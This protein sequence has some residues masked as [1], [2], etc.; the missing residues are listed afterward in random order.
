MTFNSWDDLLDFLE[1]L[2]KGIAANFDEQTYNVFVFGSSIREDYNPM[3][4]DLDLAVYACTTE[5]TEGIADFIRDYLERREVPY[6]LIEI[7]TEQYDAYVCVE[8]LGLNVTFTSY[9]PRELKE[10]FYVLRARAIWYNEETTYI[11]SVAKCVA[12]SKRDLRKSTNGLF[13]TDGR[14][15]LSTNHCKQGDPYVIH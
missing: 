12:E 5:Q 14:V 9:Y 3:A 15:E 1:E 7:S 2:S 11:R 8:P 4:S 13:V 10:Y 6:D